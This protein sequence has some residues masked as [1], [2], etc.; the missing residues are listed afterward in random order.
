M[1]QD[2]QT[3][4]L[5]GNAPEAWLEALTRLVEGLRLRGRIGQAA[6]REL[7]RRYDLQRFHKT[8]LEH[9]EQAMTTQALPVLSGYS[10]S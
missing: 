8:W 1:V 2:G 5:V 9:I 3:E 7:Q 6:R 4:L 10:R